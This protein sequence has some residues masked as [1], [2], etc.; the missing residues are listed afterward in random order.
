MHSRNSDE[1]GPQERFPGLRLP[2]QGHGVTGLSKQKA[3]Q[4]SPLSSAGAR[5]PAGLP[6]RPSEP[7]ALI[8]APS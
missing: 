4:P 3:P 8:I 1:Q 6:Q 7:V 5:E 2:T